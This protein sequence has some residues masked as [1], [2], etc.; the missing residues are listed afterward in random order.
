MQLFLIAI[1]PI[2][3]IVETLRTRVGK[4]ATLCQCLRFGTVSF[5]PWLAQTCDGRAL[6]CPW[7]GP[8]EALRTRPLGGRPRRLQS[9]QIGC[10][11]NKVPHLKPLWQTVNPE[12]RPEI[13]ETC[14][15][16]VVL[17]S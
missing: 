8:D 15:M 2:L 12:T 5:C 7:S 14:E 11:C 13:S 10:G 4:F 6:T 9:Y 1:H 3:K 16:H 17:L